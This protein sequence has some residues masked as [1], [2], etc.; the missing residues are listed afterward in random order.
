MET[1]VVLLRLLLIVTVLAE[2][3]ILI[4]ILVELILIQV[5]LV[6]L[7]KGQ[8]LAGEPVDRTRDELL[9]D[10]LTKLVIQFQALLNVGRGVILVILGWCLGRREEVEEG[11]GRDRLLDDTSLLG[12]WF[13]CQLL[14][15][16]GGV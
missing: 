15:F 16:Y 3:V 11:F 7:L 13:F 8:S 14:D 4:V 12:V 9:L 1:H 5:V 6:Y 2:V 10:V